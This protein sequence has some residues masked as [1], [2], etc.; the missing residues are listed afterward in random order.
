M[1][2]KRGQPK[3]VR[4]A[5]KRKVVSH[6]V[7]A[8]GL[9]QRRACRLADL[10]LSTWQYKPRKQERE[11]L[12][13]RLRDLA[14]ERRRFGYR[15]LH[16][17][18]RREGWRVN[19]KAVH[20]IYVE[21]GLQVRKHKRKRVSR[22]ERHP[23]LVPRGPERALVDGLPAR[24]AGHRPEVPDAQHRRRLL[25]RMPGDRGRH[26]LAGQPGPCRAAGSSVP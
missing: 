13:Q 15:R 11:G 21:E 23:L 1:G 9:S 17:L 26:L 8:H 24:P 4:P 12:R 22:S 2:A 7:S 18:L 20:R 6:L 10:K 14:A 25:A 19:H 3:V 16:V 5:G